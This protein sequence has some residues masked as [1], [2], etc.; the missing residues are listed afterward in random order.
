[1]LTSFSYGKIKEYFI[2]QSW[3]AGVNVTYVNPAYTSFLGNLKYRLK[4]NN[5]VNFND[6]VSAAFVIARRGQGLKE[7][8]P[9]KV[10]LIK[11]S[12]IND[13]EVLTVEQKSLR[14]MIF[15]ATKSNSFR[16]LRNNYKTVTTQRKINKDLIRV[17]SLDLS[18]PSQMSTF[19]CKLLS[20]FPLCQKLYLSHRYNFI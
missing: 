18:K 16:E 6:H 1:M 3:K 15:D 14:K 13:S 7:K 20:G 4:T 9:S 17:D 10:N 12:N 2:Q 11:Y 5:K 19:L 8:I